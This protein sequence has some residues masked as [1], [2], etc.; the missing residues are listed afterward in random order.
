MRVGVT[1]GGGG[2]GTIV[3]MVGQSRSLD[4]AT[5]R[6]KRMNWKVTWWLTES[7]KNKGSEIDQDLWAV[8]WPAPKW[9]WMLLAWHH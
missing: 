5:L 3:D 2:R 8:G 9:R 4:S 1:L 6:R 7:L